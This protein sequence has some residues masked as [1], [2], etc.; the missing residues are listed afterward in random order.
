MPNSIT[1]KGTGCVHVPPDTIE[2]SFTLQAKAE[3]YSETMQIAEKK[4]NSLHGAVASAGCK[5][6]DLKTTNFQVNTNYE[7]LPDESGNYRPVF[8]GYICTHSFRL[9]L[10]VNMDLL[11]QV[12]VAADQSAAEPEFS[13]SFTVKNRNAVQEKVLRDAAAKTKQ[14]AEILADASGVTLGALLSVTYAATDT[15]MVSETRCTL[16][17]MRKVAACGDN[18]MSISPDDITVEETAVFVW[19]IGGSAQ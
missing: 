12:L 9:E 18:A 3:D 16:G 11:G 5:P 7:H 14:N 13:V 4:R 19:E 17:A 2:I 8:R 1:V 15:P 6:D 10:P